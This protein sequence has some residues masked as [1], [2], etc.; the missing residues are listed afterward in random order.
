MQNRTIGYTRRPWNA[1][2]K[3][4]CAEG[5]RRCS[6]QVDFANIVFAG[7]TGMYCNSV[8]ESGTGSVS[9][10]SDPGFIAGIKAVS[11]REIFDLVATSWRTTHQPIT[12]FLSSF[13]ELAKI[14]RTM[15]VNRTATVELLNC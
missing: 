7:R 10:W 9:E 2:A 1:L 8:L 3:Q 5:K 12:M 13:I 14:D 15:T 11:V 6:R 4:Y